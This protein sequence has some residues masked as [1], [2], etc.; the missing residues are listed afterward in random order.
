MTSSFFTQIGNDIDG[1]ALGDQSGWSVSLS[2]DGSVVAI[3]APY[4]GGN[5]INSGHVRIYQNIDGTWTQVGS[6]IDGEAAGDYSGRSVSLSADGSVVAIGA[7][8]NSI[9]GFSREGQ[10]R[11]YQI[12]LD[13]TTQLTELQALTYIASNPVSYTH[14][15]LP[16]ILLV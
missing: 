10:V 12:D 13:T 7:A 14:L 11:L 16:T 15:T 8:W 2:A 1:E 3:S 4:N 6:D 5:G 9:S